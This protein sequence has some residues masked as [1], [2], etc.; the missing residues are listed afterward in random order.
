MLPKGLKFPVNYIARFYFG[1][2]DIAGRWIY[3]RYRLPN[4]LTF[5]GNHNIIAMLTEFFLT[6]LTNDQERRGI[7]HVR[8]ASVCFDHANNQDYTQGITCKSEETFPD[9][10]SE[11]KRISIFEIL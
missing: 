9:I 4:S 3:H 2:A 6:A 1:G 5:I 10:E 7:R 8:A 11:W